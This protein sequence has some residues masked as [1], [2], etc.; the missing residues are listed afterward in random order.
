VKCG[1]ESH[2]RLMRVIPFLTY[3]CPDKMTV[4]LKHFEDVLDFD[5]NVRAKKS[6]AAVANRSFI[7]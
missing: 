6:I 3:A 1:S 2:G 7:G 4:V 5:E